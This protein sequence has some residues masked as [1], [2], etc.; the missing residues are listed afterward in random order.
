M[1][2]T[3]LDVIELT[4]DAK[5][6]SPQS[7]HG[8]IS[9]GKSSN[10]DRID[11]SKI[12]SFKY[13]TTGINRLVIPSSLDFEER[14]RRLALREKEITEK[15]RELEQRFGYIVPDPTSTS[16]NLESVNGNG[17]GHRDGHRDPT[18]RT[19]DAANW[20]HS[21]CCPWIRHNIERDIE[22][23]F[24]PMVRLTFFCWKLVAVGF[25]LNIST[26]FVAA[27]HANY[28]GS[29]Q[30]AS[31]ALF[32]ALIFGL[33][34][35]P[36]SF[37]MWYMNLYR[38]CCRY[39]SARWISFVLSFG[40]HGIVS[41]FMVLG[42]PWYPCAGVF[43]AAINFGTGHHLEAIMAVINIIVW[44]IVVVVSTVIMRR[45]RCC[46]ST[47]GQSV[48]EAQDGIRRDVRRG[49]GNAVRSVVMGDDL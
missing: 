31:N 24:Q 15:A 33:A 35:I 39:S 17:N 5:E 12:G 48:E 44:F 29:P 20:P 16:G 19:P 49:F 40:L 42:M 13:T 25:V 36:L 27:F 4:P 9:L 32:S 3:N 38:L 2:V 43:F 34:A 18:K 26:I 37:I 47:I 14:E 41:V 22:E 7:N 6:P 11:S 45:A 10:S 28:Y 23:H 1:D 46:F 21:T 30:A 8:F